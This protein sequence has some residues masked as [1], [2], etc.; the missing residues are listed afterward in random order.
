MPMSSLEMEKFWV[1][2]GMPYALCSLTRLM[3][4]LLLHDMPTQREQEHAQEEDGG[5]KH[6]RKVQQLH[7]S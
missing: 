3:A 7:T 1:D 6:Y 4:R 2:P 5:D